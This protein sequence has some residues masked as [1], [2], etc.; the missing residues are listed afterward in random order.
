M[1]TL[2]SSDQE[3]TPRERI[4]EMRI[5]NLQE[6]IRELETRSSY[7]VLPVTYTSTRDFSPKLEII[8]HTLR[9]SSNAPLML[10]E[11]APN[12]QTYETVV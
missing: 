6:R 9:D 12:N 10:V 5:E 1:L 4:L 3:R 11:K 7:L 2:P 8:P